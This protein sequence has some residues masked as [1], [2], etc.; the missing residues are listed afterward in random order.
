LL[1]LPAHSIL[2]AP[3]ALLLA[4]ADASVVKRSMA[5]RVKAGE[6]AANVAVVFTLPSRFYLML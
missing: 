4:G 3:H 1:G 6:P 5:A 2:A